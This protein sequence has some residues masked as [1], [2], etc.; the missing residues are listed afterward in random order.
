MRA[1]ETAIFLARKNVPDSAAY[2]IGG[3]TLI[4]DPQCSLGI[5]AGDKSKNARLILADGV[6]AMSVEISVDAQSVVNFCEVLN[7]FE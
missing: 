7:F 1:E 4:R 5:L 2:F 6:K 3:D